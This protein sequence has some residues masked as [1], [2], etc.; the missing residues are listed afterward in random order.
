MVKIGDLGRHN[1]LGILM[2]MFASLVIVS[3]TL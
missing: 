3:H 2:L 1:A